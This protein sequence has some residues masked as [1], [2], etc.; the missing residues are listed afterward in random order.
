MGAVEEGRVVYDN[1]KK[2]L[3]YIFAH[4]TPEV[5]PFALFVLLN[6]PLP[7]V[8]MQILAIDLGTE[9][10][11]LPLAWRRKGPNLIS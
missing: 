11:R 6:I 4:A 2:F 10:L 5:I 3:A 7:L 9:T 8:V 1:M